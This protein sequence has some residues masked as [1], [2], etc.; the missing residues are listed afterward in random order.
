MSEAD[1]EPIH[2]SS[3]VQ[4]PPPREYLSAIMDGNTIKIAL[5]AGNIDA[6]ATEETAVNQAYHQEAQQPLKTI[7]DEEAEEAARLAQWLEKKEMEQANK[8]NRTVTIS[9]LPDSATVADVLPR[10]RGGVDSCYVSQFEETRVAV[11][12]FKLAADAITYADFCKETPIWGLWTFEISRPGVPFTWERRAKV[13]LYKAAPGMGSVWNR[14]DI[15]TE[16]RTLVLAGSR[17]LVYKG[18]KPHEV[19][20]IYRALGLQKSQHQRDQVEGMWLDGPVRDQKGDPVRGNLHVWYTSIKAAQEA[21][22]RVTSLEFE[23]D[24]CSDSPDKLLLY[25]DEGEDVP[26]FR[27]HEP[28]VNLIELDQK[29]ILTGI[30]EGFVDPIQAYWRCRAPLRAVPDAMADLT[31][32]LQ[33]SLQTNSGQA[34]MPTVT[35]TYQAP[36]VILP[37][38]GLSDPFLETQPIV[39]GLAPQPH[40]QGASSY[41]LARVDQNIPIKYQPFG[42]SRTVPPGRH[43]SPLETYI[44]R[45]QERQAL[46][47]PPYHSTN[48]NDVVYRHTHT[49]PLSSLT[50]VFN[51]DGGGNIGGIADSVLS[52]DRTTTNKYSNLGVVNNNNPQSGR[53]PHSGFYDS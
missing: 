52:T 50:G 51:N 22:G 53:Q 33:W 9:P 1:F 16:P 5:P 40:T 35:G 30:S 19:A 32:R 15:P 43:P 47:F 21:R 29:S 14:A 38:A 25:L 20:G 28:F 41:R 11:V 8:Y 18:C 2:K 44:A 12:T 37:P 49:R 39:T 27:H 13:Q 23:Y 17:C 7:S 24:P 26:V 3:R 6:L 34:M 4:T 10:I 46:G 36:D 45:T 42:A 48:Q 31:A